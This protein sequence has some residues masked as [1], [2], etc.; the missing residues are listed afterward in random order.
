[1]NL[2]CRELLSR[3]HRLVIFTLDRSVS[4]ERVLKGRRLKICIGPYR[5]RPR[6]RALDLFALERRYLTRAIARER[7]DLLH[8]QWTYEFALAAASSGCPHLVTAH[9]APICVLRHSFDLYRVFRTAM[10]YR[11]LKLARNVVA[12]SPYVAAHLRRYRFSDRDVPVIPNGLA[13]AN[14]QRAQ[15]HHDRPSAEVV[16]A[17]VLNGWGGRKNGQAAVKAF[18][19]V[20]RTMRGSRL[21]MFGQ[22]HGPGGPAECWATRRGM[23]DGID[24]VG[25][26]GYGSLL[27]RLAAEVDAL[28]H[29]SLEESHGMVLIEAMALGIPAIGG[30]RS[31]AVPWTLEDGRAG[32]LV[33]VRD[34]DDL[35]RA[36]LELATDSSKR[37]ALGAVG[38]ESVSRRFNIGAV[39][40]AYESLYARAL[41]TAAHA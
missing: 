18:Q 30:R 10:A 9:D 20:R 8:A 7:P 17:T 19:Q 36:M 12:V 2:L 35:A 37:A 5:P 4:D 23:A 3:G 24:F 27:G 39:A 21:L 1:V 28:V 22:D 15:A 6:D 33:D 41:M 13:A 38:R 34:P 14:F 26:L 40:D 29:P 16:Y 11:A 25:E 31:G 32:L